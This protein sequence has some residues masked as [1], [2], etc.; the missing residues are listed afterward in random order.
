MVLQQLAHRFAQ[1]RRVVAREWCNDQH[2]RLVLHAR[3]HRQVVGEAL[4]AQQP[5]EGLGDRHLLLHR[6]VD[7]ADTDRGDVELGLLVFLGQPVHQVQARRHAVRHG[8]VRERRQ[9]MAVQLGRGACEF[10]ERA[11]QGT[12]GFIELIQHRRSL[13]WQSSFD[14]PAHRFRLCVAAF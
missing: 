10:G 1:Q 7:P 11:Q 3:E 4:E 13:L 6:H 9:R 12:L 2:R 8:R 5:A 14:Q